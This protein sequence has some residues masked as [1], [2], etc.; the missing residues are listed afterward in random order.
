MDFTL[1]KYASDPWGPSNGRSVQHCAHFKLLPPLLF[2]YYITPNRHGVVSKHSAGYELKILTKEMKFHN[3]F[4]HFTIFFVLS[5]T[6]IR[7]DVEPI[8]TH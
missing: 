4:G 1:P 5:E 7:V 8:I 6:S 2:A 3:P